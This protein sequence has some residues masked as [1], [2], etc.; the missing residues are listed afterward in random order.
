MDPLLLHDF[1]QSSSSD[2]D[3]GFPG[4]INDPF[5]HDS[6]EELL[7]MDYAFGALPPPSNQTMFGGNYSCMDQDDFSENILLTQSDIE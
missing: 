1:D 4:L 3:A 2:D 5:D 7:Y 6:D